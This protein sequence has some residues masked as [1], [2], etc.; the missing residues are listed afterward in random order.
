VCDVE[1]CMEVHGS[2]TWPKR[3]EYEVARERAEMKMVKWM[4][5]IKLQDRVASKEL[6]ETR[7]ILTHAHM[8][9]RMHTHTHTHSHFMALRILSGTTRVSRYQKKHSPSHNYHGYQTSLSASSIYYNPWHPP[10]SI[11]VLTVLFHNLSPSFL[12]STAWPRTLHFTVH[13]FLH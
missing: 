8:H 10:C 3:K 5:D 2:E 4:C 1:C 9:A 12:W 13:T 7:I 6:R 11:Y